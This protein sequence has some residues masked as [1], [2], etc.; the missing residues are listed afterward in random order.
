MKYYL[1][2]IKKINYI[3]EIF[4]R[5]LFFYEKNLNSKI[6]IIP[7]PLEI[8]DNKYIKYEKLDLKEN[9]FEKYKKNKIN[10][11]DFFLLGKILAKLH[12]SNN[13]NLNKKIKLHGDFHL[14]NLFYY[15]KKIVVID[16]ETPN[17]ADFNLY[18][19]NIN[20][21]EIAYFLFILDSYYFI[22]NPS[23]YKLNI[24]LKQ[25]FLKGYEEYSKIKIDLNEINKFYLFFIKSSLKKF[26]NPIFF[27]HSF[28]RSIIVYIKFFIGKKYIK[29]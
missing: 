27:L 29:L 25:N 9:L 6:I 14:G 5:N 18:A 4:E 20:Y 24:K 1:K 21:F 11:Q 2:K 15:K 19:N 13:S 3:N 22:L 10:S 23:L 28:F 26:K 16:F 17:K 8:I 7:K 12:L